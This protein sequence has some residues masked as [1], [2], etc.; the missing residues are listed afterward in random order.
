[1]IQWLWKAAGEPKAQSSDIPFKDVKEVLFI[2]KRF[3]VLQKIRLCRHSDGVF[4]QDAP[5][6][7][8]T[9]YHLP[10]PGRW[11]RSSKVE[12]SFTDV[13]DTAFYRNAV[14]WAVAN[15]VTAGIDDTHFG[16]DQ[17]CTREQA[18]TFLNK[19]YAE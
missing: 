2:G 4:S 17:P 7:Q 11:C 1:V 8:S 18:V 3:S 15:K 9:D 13:S 12:L 10:L 16:P 5:L 19:V 6:H 14:N